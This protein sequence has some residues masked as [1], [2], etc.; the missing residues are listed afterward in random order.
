MLP[1]PPH[2]HFFSQQALLGATGV[3]PQAGP[4]NQARGTDL[5]LIAGDL[6][7]ATGEDEFAQCI[8]LQ[9][10]RGVPPSG[11]NVDV[12]EAVPLPHCIHP[13]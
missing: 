12:V 13:G 11:Q 7:E 6:V 9:R 2:R 3:G 1:Y 10:R 4:E 8:L 5:R